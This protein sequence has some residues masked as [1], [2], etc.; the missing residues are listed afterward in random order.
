MVAEL[1]QI[2]HDI[3]T[4]LADLESDQELIS[5]LAYCLLY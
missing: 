5:R 3:D 4:R 1:R 2:V